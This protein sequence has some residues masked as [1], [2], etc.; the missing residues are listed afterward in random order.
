MDGIV[1]ISSPQSINFALFFC[2]LAGKQRLSPRGRRMCGGWRNRMNGEDKER[3]K[4]PKS[5]QRPKQTWRDRFDG[6]RRNGFLIELFFFLS[7]S[8]K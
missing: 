2:L 1:D 5:K 4:K 8:S 6:S 3:T 7:F